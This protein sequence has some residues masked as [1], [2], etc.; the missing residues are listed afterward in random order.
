[1]LLCLK[2][3]NSPLS[4]I[5]AIRPQLVENVESNHRTTFGFFVSYLDLY[6]SL[7][8]AANEHAEKK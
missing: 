7:C 6:L 5:K 1:M 2:P 8:T 3:H 4:S